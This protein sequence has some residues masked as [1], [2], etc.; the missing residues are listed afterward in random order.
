MEGIM[1]P[2]ID[3]LTLM[4]VNMA[5]GYATIAFFLFK[6]LD[7]EDKE[8]WAPAFGIVGAIGL[9]G[10]FYIVFTWPLPGSFNMLYGEMS[11]LLGALFAAASISLAKGYKL[12]P[13]GIYSFF[14]G[15]AAIVC[16]AGII[17]FKLTPQPM[18]TGLS[19]ILSGFGGIFAG[20]VLWQQTNRIVRILALLANLGT[21]CIW[22]FTAYMSYWMHIPFFMKYMPK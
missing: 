22:A 15:L 9:I 13:L 20:F 12:L 5:A 8:S 2:F 10:G 18:I 6:G 11:I 17:S 21:A 3:F 14:A 16:G 1:K 4:L 19:F 7:S